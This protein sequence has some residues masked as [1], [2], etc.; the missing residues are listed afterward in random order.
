MRNIDAHMQE[1][2]NAMHDLITQQT[3]HELQMLHIQ[4]RS[5]REREVVA[6]RSNLQKAHHDVMM[7]IANNMK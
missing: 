4:Q 7:L 1:R 5:D 6:T 3:K 2:F